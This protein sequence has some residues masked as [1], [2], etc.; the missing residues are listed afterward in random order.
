M[1]STRF[2][3]VCPSPLTVCIYRLLDEVAPAD[4]AT[5]AFTWLTATNAADAAIGAGAAGVLSQNPWPLLGAG[6][7]PDRC[8]WRVGACSRSTGHPGPARLTPGRLAEGE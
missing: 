2:S 7:R 4:T 5:E 8:R 6:C 3:A 1:T